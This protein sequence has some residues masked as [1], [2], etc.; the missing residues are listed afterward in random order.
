MKGSVRIGHR[1]PRS[2]SRKI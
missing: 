1:V 2:T